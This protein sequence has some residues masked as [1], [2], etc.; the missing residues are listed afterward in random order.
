MRTYA[1]FYK[2]KKI[3]LQAETTLEAQEKAAKIFKARKHYDVAVV[4]A[5]VE[6]NTSD[7]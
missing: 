4:L 6:I 2:N 3:I 1:A 5:D 7:L